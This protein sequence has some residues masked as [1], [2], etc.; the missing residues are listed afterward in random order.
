MLSFS[1]TRACERITTRHRFL[2]CDVTDP[3]PATTTRRFEPARLE[4]VDDGAT[5]FLHS[6]CILAR[7]SPPVYY[8]GVRGPE[9]GQPGAVGLVGGDLA[10]WD[11][12]NVWHLNEKC[13]LL[14]AIRHSIKTNVA[15]LVRIY[16]AIDQSVFPYSTF[17]NSLDSVK[18]LSIK[19]SF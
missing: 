15:F 14:F 13:K 6:L 2:S 9:G 17:H 3:H 10:S 19:C 5:T 4:P 16:H 8:A 7:H 11:Q 1:L 12:L 18:A